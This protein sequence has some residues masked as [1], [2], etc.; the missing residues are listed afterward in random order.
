MTALLS[1]DRVF[2]V[3]DLVETLPDELDTLVGDRS[4]RLSDGEKQRVAI[5]RLLLT[6]PG[7]VVLD[8]ATAHL[9]AAGGLCTEL[10]STQF[11]A[12]QALAIGTRPEPRRGARD[13]QRCC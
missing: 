5:A 2:E 7:V 10:Y 8:E 3:P 11:A 4:Y 9:L 13:R 12:G 6:A 1:F